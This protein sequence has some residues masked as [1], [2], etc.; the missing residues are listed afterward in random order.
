MPYFVTVN[1]VCLAAHVSQMQ[2]FPFSYP[3]LS[4]V[5]MNLAIAVYIQV[6]NL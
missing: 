5:K 6:R 2:K 3:R 4:Q 1:I